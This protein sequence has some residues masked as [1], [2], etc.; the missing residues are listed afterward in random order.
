MM[1][2][3][4]NS[5]FKMMN[6]I[7]RIETYSRFSP[8]GFLQVGL[9]TRRSLRI[10]S[11]SGL[12]SRTVVIL[13]S[14]ISWFFL[15]LINPLNSLTNP[16]L[17]QLF[18]FLKKTKVFVSPIRLLQYAVFRISGRDDI[19]DPV[20]RVVS[21]NSVMDSL[22]ISMTDSRWPTLYLSAFDSSSTSWHLF[23]A[24]SLYRWSV[25]NLEDNEL[26]QVGSH[27]QKVVFINQRDVLG[28]KW[29]GFR[30]SI[31]PVPVRKD[32]GRRARRTQFLRIFRRST[33]ERHG[34]KKKKKKKLQCTWSVSRKRQAEDLSSNLVQKGCISISTPKDGTCPRCLQT[35]R[36]KKHDVR[37][38]LGL[39]T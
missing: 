20:R 3:N 25:W 8:T 24:W 34:K 14:W 26:G 13:I 32:S 15:I 30:T 11:L 29:T 9:E 19:I 5:K 12:G 4:I 17:D 2:R 38:N 36:S 22:I 31:F 37:T 1:H 39:P 10:F 6:H 35:S 33:V 7:G 16:V 21:S 18:L 28:F 23:V 27:V